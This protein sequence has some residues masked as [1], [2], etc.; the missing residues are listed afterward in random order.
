MTPDIAIFNQHMS[1]AGFQVGLDKGMWGVPDND[2]ERPTWPYIII[3]IKAAIKENAPDK[4]F[5]RFTLDGYPSN[6]PSACPWDNDKQV[7]LNIS[8][9]PKG[10]IV[11]TSIFKT[12]WPIALYAPCD[13]LAIAGHANW[14]KEYPDLWW[15]STDKIEKYL[16]FIHRNLN[17]ADYAQG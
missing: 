8:E 9:W 11:T 17:S 3:W 14:E 5:F 4:F 1:G 13:R 6:A 12:G 7:V 2:P 16:H 15:R 10:G